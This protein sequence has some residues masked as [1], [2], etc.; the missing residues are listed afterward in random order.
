MAADHAHVTTAPVPDGTISPVRLHGEAC[1][2][3][4][5][6][7]GPLTFVGHVYTM[8]GKSRLGWRVAACPSHAERHD[9]LATAGVVQ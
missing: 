4:G 2:V 5:D 3:C 9:L 6:A 8:S 1:I 7:N